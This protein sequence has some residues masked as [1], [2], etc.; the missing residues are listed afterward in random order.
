MAVERQ[1]EIR[2][3]LGLHVRPSTAVA[4]AASKF[5]CAIRI[6]KEGQNVNAKSSL[7]LLTLAAVQGT[8]LTVRAEG[9]REAEAVE[10]VATLIESKFGEE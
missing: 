1:V 4:Q 9:D 7:E 3:T 10:T 6:L 8:R 2:N 5:P